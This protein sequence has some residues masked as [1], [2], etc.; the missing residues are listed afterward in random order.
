MGAIDADA[1]V[2][3]CAATFGH[4]EPEFRRYRPWITSKKTAEITIANNSGGEQN[5]FW[6]IDGRLQPMEGNVGSNTARESREMADVSVRLAPMDALD[7]DVQILYPTVF[8]RPWPEDPLCELALSQSYNRWLADIWRQAP[9]RLRWVAMPP[10]L[11]M[12]RIE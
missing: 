6:V 3:E 11:S 8:L 5:Q 7:I 12:D 9:E 10:L 1:H 4:I 2:I